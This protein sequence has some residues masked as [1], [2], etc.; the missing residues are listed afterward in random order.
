MLALTVA[1][2]GGGGDA[3]VFPLGWRSDSAGYGYRCDGW[4]LSVCNRRY[5][6]RDAHPPCLSQY[7]RDVRV[8]RSSAGCAAGGWRHGDGTLGF[9]GDRRSVLPRPLRSLFCWA[10]TTSHNV[11]P[12]RNSSSR[13]LKQATKTGALGGYC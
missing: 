7:D 9:A 1:K 8:T 6:I 2:L 5:D 11:A 3:A 12:S 10:A 4:R 13:T